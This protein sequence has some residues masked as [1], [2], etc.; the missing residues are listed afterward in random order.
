[1]NFNIVD[2]ELNVVGSLML[3]HWLTLGCYRPDTGKSG[4]R[5][6]QIG[7][8]DKLSREAPVITCLLRSAL[9]R[10]APLNVC[11]LLMEQIPNI[12][13]KFRSPDKLI[14]WSLQTEPYVHWFP[15]TY[16]FLNLLHRYHEWQIICLHCTWRSIT[17]VCVSTWQKTGKFFFHSLLHFPDASICLMMDAEQY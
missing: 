5:I 1:M 13:T 10:S 16:I 6:T 17:K 12:N 15:D 3:E 7:K 9:P 2:S 8:T 14:P 4:M 11:L